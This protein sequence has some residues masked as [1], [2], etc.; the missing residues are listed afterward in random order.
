MFTMF[1]LTTDCYVLVCLCSGV[2][3]DMIIVE[4]Q[5]VNKKRETII[6]KRDIYIIYIL[7]TREKKCDVNIVNNVN[8]V[9]VKNGDAHFDENE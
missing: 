9:N 8:I 5:N 3:M 4:L 7:Y 6:R 2:I 1:T